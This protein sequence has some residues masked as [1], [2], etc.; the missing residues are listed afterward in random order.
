[1]KYVLALY[2]LF[3]LFDL[4]DAQ[5][6]M[7]PRSTV[8]RDQGIR[9]GSFYYY[10]DDR[11]HKDSI[12]VSIDN[13]D[14]TG[15]LIQK[16]EYSDKGTFVFRSTVYD[17][18]DSQLLKKDEVTAGVFTSVDGKTVNPVVGTRNVTIFEYDSAGNNI[19]MKLYLYPPPLVK[20]PPSESIVQREFD[21]QHHM[22]KEIESSKELSPYVHYT[23]F[24][25]NGLL[26]E[27]RAYD[28]NKKWMYSYVHEYD[29]KIESI[30]LQNSN[31]KTLSKEI[32]YDDLGRLVKEKNYE[33]MK[34]Y[35]DHETYTYSYSPEGLIVD[36]SIEFASGDHRYF[37]YFYSK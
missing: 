20:R 4:C 27:K 24:Y 15:N 7:I 30:Y 19:S 26:I 29:Q 22:V 34:A 28:I 1:M 23:F 31:G 35:K 13:Y 2:C 12:L 3:S 36:R 18:L 21:D 25:S 8:I 10:K 11:K 33:V 6:A 32:Y 16:D 37:K 5:P 17:Y 9:S 14:S